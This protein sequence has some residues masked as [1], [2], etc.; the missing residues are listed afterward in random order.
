MT[1]HVG[2]STR[3]PPWNVNSAVHQVGATNHPGNLAPAAGNGA[4]CNGEP[5]TSNGDATVLPGS[6]G[7]FQL[8]YDLQKQ[9]DV[10]PFLNQLEAVDQA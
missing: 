4:P 3:P 10:K 8:L 2:G 7:G 9:V 6:A 1:Q 5:C